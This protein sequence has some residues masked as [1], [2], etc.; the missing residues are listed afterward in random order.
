MP[1]SWPIIT[2]SDKL[3]HPP[4]SDNPVQTCWDVALGA[5]TQMGMMKAK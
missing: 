2:E 4:E 3:D 5:L 1:D